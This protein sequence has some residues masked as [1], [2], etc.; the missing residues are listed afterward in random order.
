ML[1]ALI[2]PAVQGARET[3][4]RTQ[5]LS[6]LR[7][8]GVAMQE[9]ESAHQQYPGWRH[10]PFPAIDTQ[11]SK[12][13]HY[14]TSW[15]PQ[16]FPYLGFDYL[17]D[18]GKP[19][20]WRRPLRRGRDTWSY[21]PTLHTVA[22]C[23]SDAT[24]ITTPGALLSYVVSCGGKDVV[25]TGQIPADWRANGM[26]HDYFDWR[27]NPN[28]RVAT[29]KMDSSFIKGGDGLANT[30]MLSENRDATLYY[31]RNE[32]TNGFIFNWPET[33]PFRAINGDGFRDDYATARPSSYHQRGVNAVFASG[34]AKFLNEDLDYLV[35]IALMTTKSE[36]AQEPGKTTPWDPQ[37]RNGP[38]LSAD[39]L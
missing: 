5:C 36:Q 33:L 20:T 35:Y 21:A 17:M 18:R 2:V 29:V 16:L 32:T 19:M 10:H 37:I 3:G 26:F 28:L 7:Q 14:S 22:V 8:L 27:G 15:F 30:L 12:P 23:N 25:P 13:F 11:T 34:A 38:K 1:I 4:R 6:K 24:K 39:D 9:F 31:D